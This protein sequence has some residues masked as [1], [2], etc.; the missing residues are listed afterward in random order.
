[1]LVICNTRIKL[2]F[3][4]RAPH[5]SSP[6]LWGVPAGGVDAKE[7]CIQAICR[8]VL[9]ETEIRVGK[10]DLQYFATLY[11]QCIKNNFVKSF[12]YEMF[13][14]QLK[15]L[16]EVELSEEHQDFCW[17]TYEQAKALPLMIGAEEALEIYQE[18]IGKEESYAYYCSKS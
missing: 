6:H 16:P 13:A 17:V 10:E 14:T 7:S 12:V 11:I 3:L 5:D 18:E 4:Q 2:L 15:Y 1:M 8:E 9:E